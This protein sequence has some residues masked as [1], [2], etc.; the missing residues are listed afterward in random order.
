M[1]WR[2][3]AA[4]RREQHA[5][6]RALPRKLLAQSCLPSEDRC[7]MNRAARSQSCARVFIAA[8]LFAAFSWTLLV[9]ISPRLH[10]GIH[11]DANRSDHFCAITLIASGSYE[12]ASQPLLISA[13]QLA[14]WFTETSSLTPAL[15]KPL[16]LNAHIFAHA[17]PTHS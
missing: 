2:G 13:P 10:A 6:A 11:H 14:V 12:H 3:F 4:G 9:S 8:V 5:R 15:V 1:R 17:P 16:F 7:A